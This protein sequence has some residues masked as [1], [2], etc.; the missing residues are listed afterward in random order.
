MCEGARQAGGD[1]RMSGGVRSAGGAASRPP[2]AV[3]HERRRAGPCA[4]PAAAGEQARWP[5]SAR[6]RLALSCRPAR[7]LNAPPSSPIEPLAHHS[8][9]NEADEAAQSLG[10]HCGWTGL[11]PVLV[12]VP[13]VDES[14]IKVLQTLGGARQRPPSA[15]AGSAVQER[16][17]QRTWTAVR[18]AET[19]SSESKTLQASVGRAHAARAI[20]VLA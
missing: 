19:L 8:D 2:Q 15:A 6:S 3:Q 16:S 1:G 14:I 5:E 17:Q 10:A 7:D 13:A 9:R 12:R 20:R 18:L 11:V 4:L